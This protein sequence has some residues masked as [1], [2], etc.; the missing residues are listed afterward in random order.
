[1]LTATVQSTGLTSPSSSPRCHD[2]LQHPGSQAK[3]LRPIG[4]PH[5]PLT[6]PIAALIYP[7]RP[8]WATL[9]GVLGILFA[10]LELLSALAAPLQIIGLRA[11]QK[12]FSNP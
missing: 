1:M 8:A 5:D 11:Q 7:R 3:D 6:L 12:F 10:V 4:G 9:I 2:R